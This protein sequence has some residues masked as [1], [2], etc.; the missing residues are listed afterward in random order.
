MGSNKRILYQF[1]LSLYCE[2]TRWNLDAKGLEYVCRD[3]LPGLHAF[4]AWCI[5]RQRCL[6]V[7][8][9]KRQSIGDSSDIAL[10]LDRHYPQRPLLPTEPIAQQQVLALEAWFDELGDHVRRHCWSLAIDLPEVSTIFFG[11]QGYTRWQQLL[12]HVSK[13]LLRLMIRRTF[14]IYE[15]QIARSNT[16][17]EDALPQIENWLRHNP[18]NYLVGEQFTL[19]DLTAASMLAPLIGPDLSPWLDSRL[20][21]SLKQRADL[22]AS[23]VG[24]W[25]LRIY[26]DYRL[27]PQLGDHHAAANQ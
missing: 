9:D 3:L 1:P 14:G 2:K 26:R 15:T 20:P 12:A 7:L 6:P 5:A 23:V 22:R 21:A 10:Y 13:P 11:F 18:N 19:A 4:T 16:R 17:I 24:Q 25:V 8:R 27:K